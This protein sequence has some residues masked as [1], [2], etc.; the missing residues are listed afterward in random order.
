MDRT[1]TLAELINFNLPAGA[2]FPWPRTR[3]HF[4]SYHLWSWPHCGCFG[5]CNPD[6]K[7]PELTVCL[8]LVRGLLGTLV[9]PCGPQTSLGVT[10]GGADGD[11]AP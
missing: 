7:Q 1:G 4:T 3:P 6:Q 8:L 9:L 5:R 11:C 2:G 10:S